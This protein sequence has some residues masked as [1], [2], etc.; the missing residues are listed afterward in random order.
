LIGENTRYGLVD[1]NEIVINSKGE[2][3]V[4][5]TNKCG[6][7]GGLERKGMSDVCWKNR[8]FA[9]PGFPAQTRA[10]QM[11]STVSG[12]LPDPKI[13]LLRS[14][15]LYG[16]C[17]TPSQRKPSRYRDL[18]EGSIEHD[19]VCKNFE[20]K[21]AGLAEQG[22]KVSGKANKILFSPSGP[23]PPVLINS[24]ESKRGLFL[25]KLTRMLKQILYLGE[26]LLKKAI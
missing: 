21:N 15:S 8:F 24:K 23:H 13:L 3:K 9:T 25:K 1:L 10:Q 2:I 5:G 20:G 6:A 16:L 22:Q 7:I 26:D 19:C 11:R 12:Q 17:P 14:V 18:S 4:I